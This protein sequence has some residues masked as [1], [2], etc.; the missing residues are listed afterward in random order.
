[1]ISHFFVFR[2]SIKAKTIW[3]FDFL[4]VS[5]QTKIRVMYGKGTIGN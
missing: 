3:I 4:F 5:L 1:M 2:T